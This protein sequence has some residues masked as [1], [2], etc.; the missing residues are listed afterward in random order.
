MALPA[1]KLGHVGEAA[2]EAIERQGWLDPL[3]DRLQAAVARIYQ[4]GGQ[5][6]RVIRDLLHG[7]WLGHP[8]HPV[9]T[10]IP[11]GAWTAALV[12][13][14]MDSGR[15]RGFS[16]AADTSI[17]VGLAGAV[18]AAATGLTDWHHTTG[19]DRRAGL[20]HGL[21]NTAAT[22]LYAGS[23]VTRRRGARAAGQGLAS[24]GFLVALG[25]AYLGG[26]L[27]YGKRIGVTHAPKPEPSDDFIPVLP[28]AELR[29]GTPRR[30]QARDMTL[31]LVRQDGQIYALVESCAHLGGPLSE[32]TVEEDSIRCPWHGSRFALEDGRVL[33]GPSTF[34]QPCFEVRIRTG[35]VEVR[36]AKS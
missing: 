12:L 19:G 17:G 14:A 24:A 18:G 22:V 26:H 21:M 10:D 29:E 31:V 6:G 27:V 9:L 8:L 11:L 30:V 20:V 3:G 2:V 16:R 33:E 1:R 13:D 23:L 34:P 15:G 4:A 35:Q 25:A 28:E 36:A 7:T 32:G 5:T